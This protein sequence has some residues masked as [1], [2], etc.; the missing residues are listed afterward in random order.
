[1]AVTR[2]EIV[3]AALALLDEAG[4]DGLT[5]RRLADRLGIRAPTLYWHV[6]DK[7]ELLDLVASA[8][9]DQALAGWREP[10]P[11]QAWWDWLAGRARVMRSAL[12]AHRDSAMIL[13][14]NRPTGQALPGIE[15]QLQALTG[16]GFSPPDAML[17]LQALNAYVIGEVLDTQGEAAR[18]GSSPAQAPSQ[19]AG[20]APMGTAFPLISAAMAALEPFGSSDQRFEHGLSLI[21]TGLRQRRDGASPDRPAPPR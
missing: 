20:P 13:A 7:R 11:G 8:I 2:D 14:G 4:L 12:L 18:P 1:V 15:R 19:A 21:I 9:M 3:A 16:A 5:L 6:R 17:A 10:R